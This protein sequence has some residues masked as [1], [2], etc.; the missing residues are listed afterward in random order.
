MYVIGSKR[1]SKVREVRKVWRMDLE[2]LIWVREDFRGE[3]R[4]MRGD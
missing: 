3:N 2:I 4:R 1:R